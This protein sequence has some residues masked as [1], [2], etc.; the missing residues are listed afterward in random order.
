[1]KDFRETFDAFCAIKCIRRIKKAAYARMAII[2]ALFD[3]VVLVF[4]RLSERAS[5]HAALYW[6]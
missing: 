3:F 2:K 1:M 5:T 6:R 4:M